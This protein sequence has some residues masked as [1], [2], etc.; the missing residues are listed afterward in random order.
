MV[1]PVDR[2]QAILLVSEHDQPTDFGRKT[3]LKKGQVGH[4]VL[5]VGLA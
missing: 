1:L 3:F 2:A 5:V 4:C